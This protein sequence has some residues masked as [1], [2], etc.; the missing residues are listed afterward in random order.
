MRKDPGNAYNQKN[1]AEKFTNRLCHFLDP[2]VKRLGTATSPSSRR[3]RIDPILRGVPGNGRIVH[4][5]LASARFLI[6][7][8]KVA[9]A[10]RPEITRKMRGAQSHRFQGHIE[11]N[12]HGVIIQIPSDISDGKW[13]MSQSLSEI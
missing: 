8:E 6:D 2:P 12:P 11:A 7:C 10:S 5:T 9:W 1:Q 3:E 4:Q 13:S